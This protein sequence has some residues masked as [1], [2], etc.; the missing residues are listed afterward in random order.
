VTRNAIVEREFPGLSDGQGYRVTSPA[1]PRYNCIAWAAGDTGRWWWPDP[2]GGT[3]WPTGAPQ[4]AT[5]A[6]FVS[7]FA[8][9]GYESCESSEVEQGYEK[10][11]LYA[12]ASG[13]P[14]HAARQL[15]S[16]LWTSKLGGYV[17]LEHTAL[18]G[19]ENDEYGL[20][21]ALMRRPLQR[22]GTARR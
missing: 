7:A 20:V 2:Y 19:V 11:A 16:G 6:S 14:T 5:V 3:Y 15:P 12:D 22:G 18:A 1:D 17:D 21:I 4:E 8:S 9:I 10:V 13:T